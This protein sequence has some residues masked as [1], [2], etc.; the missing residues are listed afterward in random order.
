MA[1]GSCR[2]YQA[3]KI[4][5]YPSFRAICGTP[6]RGLKEFVPDSPLEETV[7]SEPVSEPKFPGNSEI[8][9]DFRRS[10]LG[11]AGDA[12]KLV[13]RSGLYRLIPYSPEQGSLWRLAGN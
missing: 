4:S 10:G 2:E 7:T 13:F 8:N 11:G 12:P 9:R 3:L 5:V 6:I 1:N